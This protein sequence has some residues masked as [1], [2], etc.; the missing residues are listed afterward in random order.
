MSFSTAQSKGDSA[1]SAKLEASME[2]QI[3]K[4]NQKFTAN[5]CVRHAI[6]HSLY[7]GASLPGTHL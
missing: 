1:A 6:R 7:P 2:Q 4:V 3:A 5:K